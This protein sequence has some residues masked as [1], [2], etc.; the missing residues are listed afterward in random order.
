MRLRRWLLAITAVALLSLA[1]FRTE[2]LAGGQSARSHS[3]PGHEDL[4][5]WVN[6]DGLIELDFEGEVGFGDMA[7]LLMRRRANRD[8]PDERRVGKER[9]CRGRPFHWAN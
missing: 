6:H 2:S 5:F 1:A 9:R 8:R 7:R 3:L 4:S